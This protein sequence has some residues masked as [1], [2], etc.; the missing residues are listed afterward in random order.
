MS[1][2]TTAAEAT[3]LKLERSEDIN[4]FLV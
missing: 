1:K 3:V 4:M 2:R